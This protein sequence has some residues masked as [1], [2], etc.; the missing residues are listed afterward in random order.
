MNKD[1]KKILIVLALFSL[2]GAIVGMGLILGM[3]IFKG[4]I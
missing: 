1:V 3:D 4:Y 2:A